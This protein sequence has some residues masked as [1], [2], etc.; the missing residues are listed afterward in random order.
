MKTLS[1]PKW[2]PLAMGALLLTGC[3]TTTV[4]SGKPGMPAN[5]EYDQKWHHGVAWGIAEPGAPYNLEQVCPNGWSEIQTE[6]SFVNGVVDAATRGIY[7][8]Q[9]ISVRCAV[10]APARPATPGASAAVPSR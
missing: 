3:Y 7:S 6:T 8:P 2:A 4:Y 9:T 10:V 1:M 5:I